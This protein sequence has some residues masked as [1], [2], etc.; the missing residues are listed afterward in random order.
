GGLR[1]RK[2]TIQP[3]D[4]R[5]DRHRRTLIAKGQFL[6]GRTGGKGKSH[7]HA[8]PVHQLAGVQIPRPAE[9]VDLIPFALFHHPQQLG[10]SAGEM[11]RQKR[12]LPQVGAGRGD[13][14]GD[15]PFLVR[16][17]PKRGPPRP[18]QGKA[19]GKPHLKHRHV[20]SFLRPGSPAGTDGGNSHIL[21]LHPGKQAREISNVTE[22]GDGL[23]KAALSP[24]H[25]Q[26][27]PPVE[28]GIPLLVDEAQ[29]GEIIARVNPEHRRALLHH[30][31]SAANCSRMVSMFFT[32][33]PSTPLTKRPEFSSPKVLASSTASLR[34]TP[35]GISG[36]KSSSYT[37]MRKIERSTTANRERDQ[38][39]LRCCP[40]TGSMTCRFSHTPRTRRQ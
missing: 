37:A 8:H 35:Y 7:R 16:R 31:P 3:P 27:H 14:G 17:L 2:G 38:P 23:L 1:P 9:P 4:G 5:G 20:G 30:E 22:H 12:I 19:P 6:Q 39:F 28:Q 10:G 11:D 34:V 18:G 40:I 24:G 33:P 29:G 21:Q 15:V 32:T 25:L 26:S 36:S 13:A